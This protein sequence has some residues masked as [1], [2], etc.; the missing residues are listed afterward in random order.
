MIA[1]HPPRLVT[2]RGEEEEPKPRLRGF[3]ARVKGEARREGL[4]G[5]A[6]R[7]EGERPDPFCAPAER[8]GGLERELT[9]DRLR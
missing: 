9:K 4:E 1:R 8:S 5:E 3:P 2:K 6:R 7:G